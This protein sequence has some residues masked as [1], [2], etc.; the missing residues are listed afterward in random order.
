MPT[1]HRECYRTL[2]LVLP[3]QHIPQK[4]HF[5]IEMADML[6]RKFNHLPIAGDLEKTVVPSRTD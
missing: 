5:D 4:V 6:Q 2:R 3:F 1:L